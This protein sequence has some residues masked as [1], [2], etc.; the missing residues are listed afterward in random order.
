MGSVFKSISALSMLMD[1]SDGEWA[2]ST[3]QT[4][5]L[6]KAERKKG[7]ITEADEELAQE[8]INFEDN[9]RDWSSNFRVLT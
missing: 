8:I 3:Y 1:D 5:D 6:S 4:A 7:G 9:L 2:K